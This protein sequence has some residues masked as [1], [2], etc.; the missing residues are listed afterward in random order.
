MS[1]EREMLGVRSV[2]LREFGVVW[3]ME[4]GEG[5]HFATTP[6]TIDKDVY[7]GFFRARSHLAMVSDAPQSERESVHRVSGRR[8][9]E[10]TKAPSLDSNLR[11]N[12]KSLGHLSHA[13]YL[14]P[15]PLIAMALKGTGTFPM[16]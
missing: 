16:G 10:A 8:C 11:F 4:K 15:V 1:L 5:G 12:F 3:S 13:H 6:S 14:T 7:A 9:P 2:R